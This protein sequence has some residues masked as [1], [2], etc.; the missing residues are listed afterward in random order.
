MTDLCVLGTGNVGRTLAGALASTGRS[1]VVGTRDPGRP[2]LVAWADS[3]GVE[4]A[5]PEAAATAG[6]VVILAVAFNAISSVLAS[7]GSALNDKVV[8]DVTNPLRFTDR[9]ELAIGFDDSGGDQVQRRAAASR[10]VKAFNTIGYELMDRRDPSVSPA[11]LFIATDHDDARAAAIDLATALG[12]EVHD[13]GPLRSARLT[14][15]LAMLWI[16]HAARTGGRDHVI[17]MTSHT[18]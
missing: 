5:T 9:L 11:T 2:D 15:P 7:T 12:W 17:T 6:D 16:E 10:V 1:V 18:R 8:V 13:A 3:A 4:L 14:E